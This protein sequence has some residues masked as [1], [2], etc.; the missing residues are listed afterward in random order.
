MKE[1]KRILG[2]LCWTL[3]IKH[4]IEKKT[5]WCLLSLFHQL[6]SFELTCE[7]A[8]IFYWEGEK[9]EASGNAGGWG[10]TTNNQTLFFPLRTIT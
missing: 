1:R 2:Y 10:C 8:Q 4:H 3:Q 9:L 7:A 6:L 5:P